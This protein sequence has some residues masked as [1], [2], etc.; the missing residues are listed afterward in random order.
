ML[1][2][3]DVIRLFVFL[4]LMTTHAQASTAFDSLVNEV[5]EKNPEL[6]SYQA[7]IDAAKGSRRTAGTWANPAVSGSLAQKKVWNSE[8]TLTDKGE[9]FDISIT[10]TIEWPG[11]VGLRKA[12]A[13]R[14]IELAELGLEQFRVLLHARTKMAR[15]HLLAAREIEAAT[16]EVSSH[17][18]TLKEVLGQRKPAGLTPLLET[19]IIEAMELNMQ[20][21]A[22]R[23]S[24]DAQMA[25]NDLNLLR[26]ASTGTPF[27]SSPITLSFKPLAE[28]PSKLNALAL[29]NDYDVRQHLIE[30][31]RQNSRVGL[32][33]NERLPAISIG[34]ALSQEQAGDRERLIGGTVSA[35]LP[36]WDLNQGNID[37]EKAR[38]T[39]AEVSLDLAKKNAEYR[40]AQAALA[41][42]YKLKEIAAWKP[43]AI[44]HF[45]E[46][47]ELADR[48][49]RL[50]AVPVTV[51]VELQTQYLEALQGLHDTRKEA[52]EAATQL[53]LLTGS[54]LSLIEDS[55]AGDKK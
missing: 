20:R 41:Y 12:I 52:L 38:R 32:A 45:K 36:F 30:L 39:Q 48:H 44:L 46:A 13:D 40:A 4:L 24:L 2:A 25:L 33:E 15:Y 19:R 7:E 10:Q 26:G 3:M 54:S 9:A 49:Y 34:P 18:T 37:M 43:E 22:T 35:P 53:E 42:D 31:K 1:K 47:A 11:R 51:F 6:R 5:F 50:G 17:F 14:D 8:E 27:L 55:S 29:S 23:S 28:D 16:Q 21:K